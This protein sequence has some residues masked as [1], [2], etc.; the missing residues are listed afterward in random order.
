MVSQDAVAEFVEFLRQALPETT[1]SVDAPSHTAGEWFIDII[2]NDFETQVSWQPLH[3]FGLFTAPVGYGDRP[4]EIFASPS[5]AATRVTQVYLEW[6]H[7]HRIRAIHLS[8]LR[9]ILGV[10]QAALASAMLLSQPAISRFESRD[11][12]KISTLS[13]YVE[14]IGGR[15]DIRANFDGLGI[16]V[17]LYRSQDA[18]HDQEEELA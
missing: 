2:H 17:D 15:L 18:H 5:H 11:D 12:V 16:S 4:N 7:T 8:E 9:N 13:S 10:Q 3:G 1:V 14:A 6:Q